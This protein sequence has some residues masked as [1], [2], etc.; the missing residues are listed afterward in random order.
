MDTTEKL[1]S[2]NIYY[3]PPRAHVA[4]PVA[5]TQ[6]PVFF[7]VGLTKFAVMTSCT[8]G[9]YLIYWFYKN[10][11]QVPGG[12]GNRM[13]PAISAFFYPLTAYFLFKEVERFSGRSGGPTRISAICCFRCS[14]SSRCCR[15]CS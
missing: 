8:L 10:W 6:D 7:P 15:S 14:F 11:C 2:S 1:A 12:S 5:T 3:A 4:D 9:C 13:R